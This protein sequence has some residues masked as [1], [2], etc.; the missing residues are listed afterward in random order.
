MIVHCLFYSC[1]SSRVE[2]STDQVV[3]PVNTGAL[4]K[5]VGKIPADVVNDM[6]SLAPMLSRL[7]YDP[8]ANPP[9]Y[10]KPDLLFLNNT[11]SIVKSILN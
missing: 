9:N 1:F 6:A 5:W 11:K 4:F 3:K 10:N 7:G 8:L 2:L